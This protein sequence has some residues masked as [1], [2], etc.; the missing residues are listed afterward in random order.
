MSSKNQSDALP[1]LFRGVAVRDELLGERAQQRPADVSDE[2]EGACTGVTKRLDS[3]NSSGILGALLEEN[4]DE[5]WLPAPEYTIPDEYT[6]WRPAELDS[7]QLSWSQ[8]RCDSF[9]GRPD[10]DPTPNEATARSP[11]H[12]AIANNQIAAIAAVLRAQQDLDPT[13]IH[14]TSLLRRATLLLPT[15]KILLRLPV[16]IWEY[17]H[18]V[19]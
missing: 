11:L 9:I 1:L 3:S 7:T 8:H 14:K 12:F 19:R 4:D 6:D 13:A 15:S 5:A 18:R 16:V 17:T 10:S 2:R